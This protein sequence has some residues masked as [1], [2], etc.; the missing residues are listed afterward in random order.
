M[1]AP[2]AQPPRRL[3]L[4]RLASVLSFRTISGKLIIGLI[5]LFALASVVISVVT[6]QSLNNSLMS[7]LKDQ[8]QAATTTWTTCAASTGRQQGDGDGAN[9]QPAPGYQSCSAT[10]Q[11]PG[12]FLAVLSS[13][14]TVVFKDYVTKTCTL[15][16]ADHATLVGLPATPPG[17]QQPAPPD[18]DGP[19]GGAGSAPPAQTSIRTLL[20]V[21]FM[22]TKVSSPDG[23][24]LI[25][26]LPLTTVDQELSHV[27]DTEHLIFVMVGALAVLLGAV[28]VQF[29]LRPLRRVA[30]TATRVT[31]LPLDSGEVSL[32]DGVPDTDPRTEVGQVGAAFN[33]MLYHVERALGRR[34][35]SE[36]RLRRFAADASHELRTPLSAIRGY[37]ELALRHPGP[38]PGEVTHALGRV[39]SESARM[40]VLVDDLLLL[41]R[42]DAGRPLEREPVDL[43]RLAIDVT[44]DARVARSDHR[45][46]LDLPGEPILVRGDEHRLH[47]VLANLM[48]NAGKHTP[49]G[50]TV[51]VALAT[52]DGGPEEAPPGAADSGM[53]RRG[54]RPA[55]PQV[56]LSITD[57]GPG[58]PPELL[59]ELFER[60]TR[61][62]T[63]RAR[64]ADA[65][66]TSTG[67]GLAIVDAV[68][69]AHGGSITVT[70]RPGLTRFAIFLPLLPQPADMAGVTG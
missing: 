12:T 2:G 39:Q 55:G 64:E 54:V 14:G 61:A 36:A 42:L 16:A 45:W 47:Q 26:G 24:D 56:E 67:L 63:S 40:S 22:F 48:S 31:E 19:P 1:S 70:S 38:V 25:T 4:A 65:A 32:P 5:V 20:G 59:P 49:P 53:V 18:S 44:S 35:A 13:S 51:S 68:V 52:G 8:L 7:S 66:G 15:S 21:Q 62:D 33:R 43:S 34:A 41:A 37:A 69:A 29:S 58:I 23:N 3:A 9:G 17:R 11:A 57:D 10:G 6:G 28:L 50:S 30:A 46:R 60:F 27:E